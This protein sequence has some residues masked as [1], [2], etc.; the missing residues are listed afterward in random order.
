MR[1]I[2][3]DMEKYEAQA[4]SGYMQ[5]PK[6]APKVVLNRKI[7]SFW[8]EALD[9]TILLK[10]VFPFKGEEVRRGRGIVQVEWIPGS[11]FAIDADVF[12]ELN[13][14][15]DS[16]FLYYEEQILGEKFIQHGYRMIVD[17]DISYQHNHSVSINKAMKRLAQVRQLY[18][19]KFYFYSNY[20]KIG[21][22]K[23][24]LLKALI[25]YGLFMRKILYKVMEGKR[26]E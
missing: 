19:S 20:K 17:S 15:D 3:D 16:V 26:N 25:A 10:K 12:R 14:L 23:R 22:M 11:L 4:A 13:G 18:K 7:N 8:R 1:R 9:C 21:C 6:S 24:V 5:M 2:V